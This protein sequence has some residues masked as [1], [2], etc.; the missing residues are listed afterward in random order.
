MVPKN[1]FSPNRKNCLCFPGS[2]A[3]GSDI[4]RDRDLGAHLGYSPIVPK[5]ESLETGSF[6]GRGTGFFANGKVLMSV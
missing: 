6:R 4:G 5:P 2:D 3:L 1:L